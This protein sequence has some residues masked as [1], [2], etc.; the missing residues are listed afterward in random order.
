MGSALVG[1]TAAK[2]ITT[3]EIDHRQIEKAARRPPFPIERIAYEHPVV[4]PHVSHFMQVPLRTK[5]KLPHSL[6]AS[7]S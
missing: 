5:V 2:A 6:Q 7:P 3:F 4:L 1:S